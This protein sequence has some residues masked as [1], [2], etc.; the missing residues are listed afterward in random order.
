MIGANNVLTTMRVAT[1]YN[2]TKNA[3]ATSLSRI[4][5]GKNISR[6]QDDVSYFMRLQNVRQNRRGYERIKGELDNVSAMMGLAERSGMLIVDNVKEMKRLAVEYWGSDD[7]TAKE[8]IEDKFNALKDTTADII[9]SSNFF[10]GKKLM[11]EGDVT[12]VVLSPSDMSNKLTISFDAGDIVDPAQFDVTGLSLGSAD[13]TTV[14]A[15]L[16]EQYGKAMSYLSKV[17]TNIHRIESQTAV[18][19]SVIDNSAAYESTINDV[20]DAKELSKVTEFDIRQQAALS[21]LA[22]ANNSRFGILRLLD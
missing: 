15:A 13:E 20:D 10:D 3:M 19:Q 17:G 18:A 9:N 7:A 8:A 12:S 11:K 14:N 4:A 21:M 16:D 6:P 1:F 2:A 5:S 22:Q